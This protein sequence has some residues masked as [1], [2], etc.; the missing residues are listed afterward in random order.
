MKEAYFTVETI[1]GLAAEWLNEYGRPR[2]AETQPFD[3]NRAGL[4]ILDMQE[5][6]LDPGSHAYIPG[7]RAIIAGLNRLSARFR[8]AGRPVIATQHI[9]TQAD[10]GMMAS[11]WS[12]L[13]TRDHALAGIQ[14]NLDIMPDEILQKSQY[15]AFYESPLQEIL[16]GAG[17]EQLVI[18]GV[19]THLCCETTARSAFVRGYEVFFLVDGTATYQRDF[20]TGT[21]RNLAHGIAVLTTGDHLLGEV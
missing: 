16:D 9:N 7:G 21:L 3:I 17:V 6:F 14:A 8:Q 20:H 19:L 2:K 13:I 12:E 1:K 4:L 10:A 18:G 11:W 15:D 5:Y